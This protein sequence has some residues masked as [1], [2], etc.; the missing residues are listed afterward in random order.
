MDFGADSAITSATVLTGILTA[1]GFTDSIF[2]N[3][4]IFYLFIWTL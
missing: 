4:A 3:I 1:M 2:I